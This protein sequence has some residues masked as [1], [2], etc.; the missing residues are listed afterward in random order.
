MSAP[1][2]SSNVS[3]LWLICCIYLGERGTSFTHLIPGKTAQD[4][5]GGSGIKLRRPHE[6][7]YRSSKQPTSGLPLGATVCERTELV[8]G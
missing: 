7:E 5:S 3:S 1:D 4:H 2:N 8:G 6:E